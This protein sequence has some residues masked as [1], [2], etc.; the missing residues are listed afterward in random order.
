VVDPKPI[1]SLAIDGKKSDVAHSVLLIRAQDGSQTILDGTAEQFGWPA[2]NAIIKGNE[3]WHHY[4]FGQKYSDG[5]S[6]NGLSLKYW[7]VRSDGYWYKIGISLRE[8]L[9]DLDWEGL[10]NMA[11]GPR[12]EY[13][14]KESLRR[15][16]DAAKACW[17]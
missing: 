8:M 2:S 11:T 14:R 15:A 4:T 12:E 9:R 5:V 7:K 3:F 1:H 10:A 17:G 6:S 13:I 16:L